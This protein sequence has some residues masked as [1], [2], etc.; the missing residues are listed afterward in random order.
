MKEKKKFLAFFFVQ[1][2]F[3]T[4]QSRSRENFIRKWSL[5]QRNVPYEKEQTGIS[6]FE[7]YSEF[8]VIWGDGGHSIAPKTTST[9]A[10]SASP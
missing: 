6:T 9:N 1:R 7:M 4:L 8:K 2:I 10:A 5:I 3:E